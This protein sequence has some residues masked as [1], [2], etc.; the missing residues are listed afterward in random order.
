MNK[1]NEHNKIL[2]KFTRLKD[3]E[4]KL[5]EEFEALKE[6]CVHPYL[7]FRNCGYSHWDGD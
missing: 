7:R 3:K 6:I 4:V 2:Q 1:E 5:S